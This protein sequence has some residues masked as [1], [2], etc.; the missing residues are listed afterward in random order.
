MNT[1]IHSI[2]ATLRFTRENAP[3]FYDLAGPV[4]WCLRQADVAIERQDM[5]LSGDSIDFMTDHGTIRVKSKCAGTHHVEIMLAVEAGSTADT[6]VARQICYQL[7]RRLCHRAKI[8][9]IVW[10]PSLQILRPAQFSWGVL[11][12]MPR[13]VN[14]VASARHMP[15]YGATLH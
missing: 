5:G 6:I 11:Q 15:N 14:E 1:S 10:Q 3:D 8:T 12:D 9:S 4:A 7:I 13:R 2:A